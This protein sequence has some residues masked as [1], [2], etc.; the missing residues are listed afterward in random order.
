MI[1]ERKAS[2]V[3]SSHKSQTPLFTQKRTREQV[4]LTSRATPNGTL[5]R[6]IK[7]LD[8]IKEMNFCSDISTLGNFSALKPNPSSAKYLQSTC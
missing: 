5:Q 7:Y 6:V 1:T 3:S 2:N 4:H 8:G